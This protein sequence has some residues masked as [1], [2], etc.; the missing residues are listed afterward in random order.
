MALVCSKQCMPLPQSSS[1]ALCS[2]ISFLVC[3]TK[4]A[5][6]LVCRASEACYL[7]RVLVGH[8]LPR[9]TMLLEEKS[10]EHLQKMNLKELICTKEG[11]HTISQLITVLINEHQQAAGAY[12]T[13]VQLALQC[14][15][16]PLHTHF[17][18]MNQFS[19]IAR[20]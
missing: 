1:C 14:A 11:E 9:L 20:E 10:R 3:R 15:G 7:M 13:S 12:S 18:H 19:L 6:A 2:K 16:S 4:E 17:P 8:Q 5:T